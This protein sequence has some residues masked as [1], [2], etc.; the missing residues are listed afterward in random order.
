[1]RQNVKEPIMIVTLEALFY[2]SLAV[3]SA[4]LAVAVSATLLRLAAAARRRAADLA[5]RL[6]ACVRMP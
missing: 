6:R 5:Q 4:A 3:A 1:M 2:I